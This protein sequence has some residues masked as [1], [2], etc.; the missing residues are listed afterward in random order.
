MNQWLTLGLASLALVLLVVAVIVLNRPSGA[1]SLESE[2]D[3]AASTP[4]E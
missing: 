4:V 3:A 2:P 1:P